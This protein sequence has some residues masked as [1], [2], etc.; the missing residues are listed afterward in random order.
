MGG[1]FLFHRFKDTLVSLLVIIT[2]TFILM[3]AAPGDPFSDEQ[4]LPKETIEALQNHYGLNDSLFVQYGKYLK[5]VI[6]WDLGPSLKYGHIT[7]NEFISQGFP[8]SATLGLIALIVAFSTGVTLGTIA[9]LFKGKWQDVTAMLIA[10]LGVSVPSFIVASL[11]QYSL[12]LK[13]HL[14]P[15]ARWGSLWHTVLPAISLAA[16][17]TAFIARLTRA[18]MIETMRQDYIKV[19]KMKGLSPFRIIFRHA[20]RNALLPVV[21][22]LGQLTANI[23]V[24]SF[25]VEKIFGI[26]GMGQV[27]ITAVANRDYTVIMGMTVFCSII[28]LGAILFVDIAYGFIDPRIRCR[29]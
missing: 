13:L 21:T 20:L 5:S 8:V 18:K 22:Y 15:V 16:L 17:P 4:N 12:G 1:A 24:G 27:M 23:I 29:R 28:L 6:T 19:A 9:S 26:P 10:V 14:F 11:L 25:V 2:A 3:K 7:V